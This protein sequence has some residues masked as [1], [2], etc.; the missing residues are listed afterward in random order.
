MAASQAAMSKAP[1]AIPVSLSSCRRESFL[2]LCSS[3]IAS[4]FLFSRRYCN[5]GDALL[6]PHQG[7]GYHLEPCVKEN[8]YVA[9]DRVTKAHCGAS[10]TE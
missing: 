3:H 2:K 8:E 4:P 1:E 6:T 10:G 5:R 9:Y 7:M